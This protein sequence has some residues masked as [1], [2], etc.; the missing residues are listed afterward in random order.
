MNQT[1]AI[2]FALRSDNRVDNFKS[3]YQVEKLEYT[4][5]A[6]EAS[7]TGQAKLYSAVCPV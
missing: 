7:P 6:R 3:V 4:D 5:E 2:C 1:G